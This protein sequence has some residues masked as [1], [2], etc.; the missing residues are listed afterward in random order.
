MA[1]LLWKSRSAAKFHSGKPETQSLIAENSVWIFGH[2]FNSSTKFAGW[3]L[4]MAVRDACMRL[5]NRLCNMTS[6]NSTQVSQLLNPR[7]EGNF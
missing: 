2:P 6:V 4:Q 3:K 5:F 1:V 7:D